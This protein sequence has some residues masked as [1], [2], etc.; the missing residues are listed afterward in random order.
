MK[1]ADSA[2]SAE[3]KAAVRRVHRTACKRHIANTNPGLGKPFAWECEC[4]TIMFLY[5]YRAIELFARLAS[6]KSCPEPE[7][8]HSICLS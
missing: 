3:K 2:K 5:T 1:T 8:K 7:S 4:E 6:N